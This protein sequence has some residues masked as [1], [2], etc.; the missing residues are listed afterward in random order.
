[1]SESGRALSGKRA[2]VTGSSQG[3]G[4]EIARLLA[5][6]GA[7]VVLN[8][9]GSAGADDVEAAARAIDAEGIGRAIARRGPVN[10]VGFAEELINAC[11]ETF[12]GIDILVNN[13][14]ITG[15]SQFSAVDT[16]PLE[17]WRDV[18][19][20]NLNGSFYT[21]RFAAPHMRKQRWG[22]IIH[23]VSGAAFG[24]IGGSCYAASKGGLVSLTYAMAADLGMFGVT[25]NCYA[26]QARSRLSDASPEGF[27]SMLRARWRRGFCDEAEYQYCKGF[28]GPEGVAP[29][30]GYLCLEEASYI[31]GRV[32]AVEG[33]RIGLH[34]APRE[35]RILWRQP[36]TDQP[37]RL[38]SLRAI[39]RQAFPI[40]NRW[41]KREEAELQAT[42]AETD[43]VFS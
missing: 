34:A 10:D 23:C 43:F 3:M 14:G 5:S 36:E 9:R 21:S 42:L 20:V 41:P 8:A 6:E 31:N 32:F 38:Q 12:G 19:D 18:L 13:A 39:A 2:V 29:W 7:N 40:E 24:S 35:E 4:L 30:I 22:R 15:G 33:R 28:P 11:V 25:V 16:V 37:W 17:R 1:M 26:P 27:E